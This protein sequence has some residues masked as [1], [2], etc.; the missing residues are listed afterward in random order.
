MRKKVLVTGGGSGIGF[1]FAE[2]FMELGS[3]VIICGRRADVLQGVKDKY[4][5]IITRVCDLQSE[6]SRI[7]L[8]NWIQA[9]HS[10]LDMLVNNAGIQ[11]WANFEDEDFMAK[12]KQE[13]AILETKT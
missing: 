2:K 5:S 9:E 13:F 12:A 4:P 8:F 1:G 10:D 6:S 11:H 3:T 7:D